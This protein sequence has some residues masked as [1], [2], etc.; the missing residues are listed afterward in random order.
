[1]FAVEIHF[2]LLHTVACS[3]GQTYDPIGIT[4]QW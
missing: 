1:M 3:Y 2:F 4:S